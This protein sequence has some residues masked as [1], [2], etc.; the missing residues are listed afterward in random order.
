MKA[1]GLAFYPIDIEQT[2]LTLNLIS[3]IIG[4]IGSYCP[5]TPCMEDNCLEES[6]YQCV[7]IVHSCLSVWAAYFRV[8]DRIRAGVY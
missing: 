3:L 4:P 6:V 7:E 5:P 1:Y 2:Y 8:Y